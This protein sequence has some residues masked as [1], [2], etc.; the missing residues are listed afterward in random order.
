MR[1]REGKGLKK[2]S[3]FTSE[4]EYQVSHL[5]TEKRQGKQKEK[6]ATKANNSL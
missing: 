5:H 2:C 3:A 1:S 6:G 4:I